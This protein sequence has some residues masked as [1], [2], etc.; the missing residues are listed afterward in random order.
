MQRLTDTL[1]INTD[2][3]RICSA[4]CFGVL[5]LSNVTTLLPL[6]PRY[7]VFDYGPLNTRGMGTDPH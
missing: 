2:S 3:D 1:R 7:E 5:N 6:L 4:F